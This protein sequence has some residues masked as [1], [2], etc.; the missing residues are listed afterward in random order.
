MNELML[1]QHKVDASL[2]WLDFDP[3]GK[4][5]KELSVVSVGKQCPQCKKEM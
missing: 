2:K 3:F 1:A 4:D 5:V